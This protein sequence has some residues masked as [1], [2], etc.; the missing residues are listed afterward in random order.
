MRDPR[1]FPKP[2][3][4]QPER[5]LPENT[6]NRH[7]FAFVPFS[8]GQRNCIG[9]KFAI[10]EMKVLLAAVIRSFKILPITR[11]EDL[12]FENGIVLRTHQNVKVKLLRRERY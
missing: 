2:N 4:F 10:L 12:T 8:A 11:L 1:H 6:V 9:Q 5:F 7:P 3:D